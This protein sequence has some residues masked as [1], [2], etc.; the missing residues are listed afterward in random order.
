MLHGVMLSNQRVLHFVCDENKS[1]P[2]IRACAKRVL[3][4]KNVSFQILMTKMC[5]F[6]CRCVG[7]CMH[8]SETCQFSCEKALLNTAQPRPEKLTPKLMKMK[9]VKN[10]HMHMTKK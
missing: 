8:V 1:S 2:N 6:L 3:G 9:T 4:N 10:L 7:V 5:V